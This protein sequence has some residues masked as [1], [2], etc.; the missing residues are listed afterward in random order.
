MLISCYLRRG[1]VYIP[2][3]GKSDRGSF[4]YIDPVATVPVS[5]T[6]E[7][8]KAFHGVAARGNPSIPTLRREDH[9]ESVVAKAAGVK[10]YTAFANRAL[11]WTIEDEDN[12]VRIKGQKK[13]PRGGW[14]DDPDNIATLPHGADQ[15]KMIEELIRIVQTAANENN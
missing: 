14:V 13:L 8:R 15:S 6:A 9:T 12:V 10:T 7:L 5:D 2:T 11:S 1:T 4:R 3:V